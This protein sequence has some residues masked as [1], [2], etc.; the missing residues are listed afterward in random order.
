VRAVN[1]TYCTAL[2][3]APP[4]HGISSAASKVELP[5][6]RGT[7]YK[8]SPEEPTGEAHAGFVH[9]ISDE[10]QGREDSLF[11]RRDMSV[12]EAYHC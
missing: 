4:H 9:S 11:L 1:S 8:P 12:D 3:P 5:P 6:V 7:G 2:E 10:E